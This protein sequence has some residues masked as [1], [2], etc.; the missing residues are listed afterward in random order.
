[1]TPTL[2]AILALAVALGI[3]RELRGIEG[4]FVDAC[5][6]LHPII[7]TSRHSAA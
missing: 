1:M 6:L 7:S 2:I 5:G 4:Q 3:P